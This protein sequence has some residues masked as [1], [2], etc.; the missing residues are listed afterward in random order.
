MK[1]LSFLLFTVILIL[2]FSCTN[3]IKY[4]SRANVSFRVT[5]S[6]I[7]IKIPL[8][9][10]LYTS[11]DE[12]IY[13][14]FYSAET[15]ILKT[16][17]QSFKKIVRQD[18]ISRLF[19]NRE[20]SN[21]LRLSPHRFCLLTDTSISLLNGKEVRSIK[22]K[23]TDPVYIGHYPDIHTV[24]MYAYGGDVFLHRLNID[25]ES[26]ESKFCKD[27]SIITKIDT[28]FGIQT[29]LPIFYPRCYFEK[30]FPSSLRI[31]TMVPLDSILVFNFAMDEN[32]Y[33][34][35]I[36]TE[37]LIKI[38]CR[39]INQ[40]QDINGLVSSVPVNERSQTVMDFYLTTA[41]YS[42]LT[43]D[44]YNEKFYRVFTQGQDL[45][46]KDSLFNSRL[47][48]KTFIMILN[49]DFSTLGEFEIDTKKYNYGIVP[50]KNGLAVPR[51][52]LVNN[53]YQYDIFKIN[54]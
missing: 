17:N 20:V 40:L 53:T 14:T 7:G 49:K 31:A 3:T 33:T 16:Y 6:L 41:R 38:N 35:N 32:L 11:S 47:D 2:L 29:D 23:A 51:R 5:D 21:A 22:I 42:R 1:Y 36:E 50:T 18:S 13:P 27:Q 25:C 24:P 9:S 15:G 54:L 45:M 34:Y 39:S 48:A 8:S 52:K 37:V 4:S 26:E 28:E 43:Y 12:N 10:L 30:T 19:N 46:N 44:P